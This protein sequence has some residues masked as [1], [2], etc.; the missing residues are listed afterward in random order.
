MA[1]ADFAILV[2]R[3][4][5]VH[6]AHLKIM[7]DA[8]KEADR[9]IVVIGSHR[10]PRSLKNPWSFERRAEMIQDALPMDAVR[11]TIIAPLRDF[12]YN[13]TSWAVGLQNVVNQVVRKVDLLPDHPDPVKI[14]LFGHFKDDSSQYLEWFPQ[15][16]LVRVEGTPGVNSRDIRET[17][18]NVD[19][20]SEDWLEP[21]LDK[22]HLKTAVAMATFSR[23]P[24]YEELCA[25][26][27]FIRNYRNSWDRAPFPPV[28]VTTDVVIVK[29]GH[30]LLVTRGQNPGK[31]RYA[32]PGGFVKSDK[33]VLESALDEVK[34][35]TDILFP[36]DE[37]RSCVKATKMFDHPERDNRGRTITHAFFIK[38]PAEGQL[39]QIKG[40]DDASDAVWMPLAE[41]PLHEENFY[42][43][44]FHI[45]NSFLGGDNL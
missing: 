41:L 22:L 45:I 13:D 24:E 9:L 27:T 16:E 43:D 29:G 30:V 19:R 10:A 14:K 3:F 20:E 35:E 7:E 44:H 18:F 42:S 28:F 32:L 17:Y 6:R 23:T 40:G 36:R 21:H 39:P 5:P 25:E 1:K 8:L 15:W 37:L 33:S 38:L 4:Q 2:G 26:A 12:T 34:E 31:G 11:R